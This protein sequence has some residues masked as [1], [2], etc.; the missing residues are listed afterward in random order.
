MGLGGVLLWGGGFRD[1]LLGLWWRCEV[2]CE[3]VEG[4]FFVCGSTH[5]LGE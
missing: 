4:V 5:G 1:C 3:G 2:L